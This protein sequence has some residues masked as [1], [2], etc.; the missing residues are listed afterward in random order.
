MQTCTVR[1]PTTALAFSG[2]FVV[3][4]CIGFLMATQRR[5]HWTFATAALF[6]AFGVVSALYTARYQTVFGGD[7]VTQVRFLRRTC[8]YAYSD[9]VHIA[10]GRGKSANAMTLTF[11]DGR[12]MAVYGAEKQLMKAQLFLAR[13]LPHLIRSPPN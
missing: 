5:G 6:V 7:A 2:F 8:V 1:N 10:I 9:V 12:E 4:G 3:I 11:S 13:K